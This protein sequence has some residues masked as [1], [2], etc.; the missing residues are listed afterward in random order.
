M[1]SSTA[2]AIRS[3]STI[4]AARGRSRAKRRRHHGPRR[5]GGLVRGRVVIVG[6]T[7]ESVRITSPPRSTPASATPT[8][9]RHRD[10]RPSRR[11]ADPRWRRRRADAEWAAARRRESVDLGA[12][13]WPARCSACR[14]A[15]PSPAMPA[16]AAGLS[17]MA[18]IVYVA[19]GAAL[20]LPALPAALAWVGAGGLDQPAALRRE[21]PRPRPAA[22]AAS[23]ITCR[24][25]SSSRWS[26]P[27]T[28]PQLG[29]ERRE[30]SV[31]FTDV[32]GFTTLFREPS[33]RNFW[34]I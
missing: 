9:S 6:I 5:V 24:R 19:F 15:R 4:T 14:S 17:A 25:R 31:L 23:S 1:S 32:A 30:I 7:A 16:I 33:T 26:T 21:Q 20:L 29:G 12:G 27:D 13:R 34:P 18:G 22:R 11:P 28:L 3:C 8:R 10:P 2:A